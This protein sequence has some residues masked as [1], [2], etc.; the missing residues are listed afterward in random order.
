MTLGAR[1]EGWGWAEVCTGRAPREVASGCSKCPG[2]K[3]RASFSARGGPA[4]LRGSR[5]FGISIFLC[6]KIPAVKVSLSLLPS[7]HG[8][9]ASR[10]STRK[11]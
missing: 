10:Q 3:A 5:L 7:L 6:H 4:G 11:M 9:N 8:D 1:G 2:P